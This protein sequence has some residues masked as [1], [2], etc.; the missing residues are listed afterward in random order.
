MQ[1]GL[2]K[3]KGFT[4]VE[5]IV[6]ITLFTSVMF[7]ATGALL[8]IVNVNKKAQAQQSAINNVNFA[9]EN[10]ARNIRT[11]STY[12]CGNFDESAIL[13]YEA[14]ETSRNGIDCNGGTALIFNSN[15]TGDSEADTWA[16]WLKTD[17]TTQRK[18]IWK[19]I[20]LRCPDS[21]CAINTTLKREYF[22]VTADEIMIDALNF[23]VKNSLKTDDKQPRV[24]I[25]IE[26]HAFVNEQTSS[27]RRVDFSLQ[28]MASQRVLDL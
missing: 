13:S 14:I 28:T 12:I 8:S 24:I 10:M 20:H 21:G 4:L 23:D 7:I 2:Q 1:S 16:Y 18:S 3:Q 6:S 19:G 15:I 27:P 26:G 17:P 9:L 22:Q 5:L 25:N 11:G